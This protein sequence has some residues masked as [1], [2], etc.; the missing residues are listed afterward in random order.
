MATATVVL[1][2]VFA[3][4]ALLVSAIG[5]FAAIS[6][7]VGTQLREIAIRS[8]LGATPVSLVATMTSRGLRPIV[9]GIVTGLV[10]AHWTGQFIKA[11]LVGVALGDPSTLIIVVA[12][13]AAVALVASIRPG[14]RVASVDPT[15]VLRQ[16]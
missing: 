15:A 10:I 13:L 1:L 7:N 11:E 4:A 16:H 9:V 3:G 2:L 14:I 8:A 5:V 6:Y 12:V